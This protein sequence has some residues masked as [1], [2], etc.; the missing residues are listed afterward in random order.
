MDSWVYLIAG[1]WIMDVWIV[2]YVLSFV[3][4]ISRAHHYCQAFFTRS[5][6]EMSFCGA[7]RNIHNVDTFDT[8]INWENENITLSVSLIEI[9][10]RTQKFRVLHHWIK[11]CR[12]CGLVAFTNMKLRWQRAICRRF[13]IIVTPSI[14]LQT[15]KQTQKQTHKQTHKHLLYPCPISTP[16]FIPSQRSRLV[17]KR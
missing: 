6:C 10:T 14:W 9:Y 17:G 4:S 2:D 12:Q 5:T 1:Q 8:Y 16:H 15:H 7:R 13:F 11:I 3:S